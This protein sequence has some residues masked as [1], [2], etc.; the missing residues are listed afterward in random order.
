MRT[1]CAG[2]AD[3]LP[4]AAANSPLAPRP[5]RTPEMS[6]EPWPEGRPEAAGATL[7]R[8]DAGRSAA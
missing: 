2:A 7:I 6:F 3:T 1:N 4:G 8:F 5:R